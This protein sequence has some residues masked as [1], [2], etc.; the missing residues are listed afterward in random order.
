MA[1]FHP[2]YLFAPAHITLTW[3]TPYAGENAPSRRS[4][5]VMHWPTTLS[6]YQAGLGDL[7]LNEKPPL[8]PPL[9]KS[10]VSYLSI[11]RISYGLLSRGQHQKTFYTAPY[12]TPYFLSPRCILGVS[13]HELIPSNPGYSCLKAPTSC[14]S[15]RTA[16]AASSTPSAF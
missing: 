1:R 2:P 5:L 8:T 3:R 16:K 10:G 12:L 14:S 13:S 4:A 6:L 7:D 11:C 9:L 15:I